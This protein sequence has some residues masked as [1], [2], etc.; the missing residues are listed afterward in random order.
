MRL[1]VHLLLYL[2]LCLTW[3]VDLS[4][5]GGVC[6]LSC[7]CRPRAHPISSPCACK[8]VVA[9]VFTLCLVAL[10]IQDLLLLGV[11]CFVACHTVAVFA[12]VHV[13]AFLCI[14]IGALMCGRGAQGRTWGKMLRP[15]W[16]PIIDG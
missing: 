16:P 6:L 14:G 7:S 5:G 2:L 8:E 13:P 9:S 11:L 4:V 3:R 10:F 12:A 1:L 15:P